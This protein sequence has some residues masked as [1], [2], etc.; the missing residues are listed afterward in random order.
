MTKPSNNPAGGLSRRHFLATAFGAAAAAGLAGPALATPRPLRVGLIGADSDAISL[1]ARALK[2]DNR[3][4]L[5]AIA[6]E[7]DSRA[8]R[9][10]DIF[11][12]R[13]RR[14]GA[15]VQVVVPAT[16]VFV[17]ADAAE[18]LCA[19]SGVDAVFVAGIPAHRPRQVATALAAGKSVFLI[20]PG[21]T[22]VAGCSLLDE[23]AQLAADRG[24]IIGVEL[25][26]AVGPMRVPASVGVHW[27]RT[28]WRRQVPGGDVVQNWYF[29]EALS[30]GPL[31][32]ENFGT[33]DRVNQLMGGAPIAA[34][35]SME[36]DAAFGDY[37]IEYRYPNGET[38]QLRS[39][40]GVDLATRFEA[41][42]ADGS[43]LPEANGPNG[44]AI[45]A[46]LDGVRSGGAAEWRPSFGRLV[47]T[48]RT[49]IL[50]RE[51]A[52]G[53]RLLRWGEFA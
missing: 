37:A 21:A 24:L 52:R 15:H 51:A 43:A 12:H 4:Q 50:G 20:G 30:G 44:G 16:G 7:L 22:N 13:R 45:G 53:D 31:L 32:M 42:F 9:A 33:I 10:L 6:D 40:L 47:D 27:Q 3:F 38:F 2:A 5:V 1:L 28:P 29:D 34:R 41:Q 48:T 26:D 49:A 19:Q 23:A 25:P 46:F 35:G 11:T 39:R 36:G 14:G 17:G 18:R 8:Q